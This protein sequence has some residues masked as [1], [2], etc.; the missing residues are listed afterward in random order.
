MHTPNPILAAI[1]SDPN[2]N[3]GFRAA[4][5]RAE[6]QGNPL[7]E[8]QLAAYVAAL[9][10][11]D[12]NFE[13]SDDHAFWKRCRDELQRLRIV[14]EEVDKDHVLWRRHAPAEYHHG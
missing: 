1:I 6:P 4:V 8:R 5:A 9:V 2:I 3:A 13:Y 10:R 14:R 12:W 11:F 7:R